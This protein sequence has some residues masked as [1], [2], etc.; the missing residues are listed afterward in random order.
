MADMRLTNT[1]LG[2][3]AGIA[4]TG[5]FED[6][7]RVSGLERNDVSGFVI[8]QSLHHEGGSLPAG[9]QPITPPSIASGVTEYF[10]ASWLKS[11]PL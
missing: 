7:E 11:A 4:D 5:Q 10:A 9:T 3:F 6:L 2:L 8:L 1:L